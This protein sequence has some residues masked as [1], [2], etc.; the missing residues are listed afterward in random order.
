MVKLSNRLLL[1]SL[2]RPLAKYYHRKRT[3]RIKTYIIFIGAH[4]EVQ[5]YI[6]NI[7][8]KFAD[9]VAKT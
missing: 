5:R 2:F 1:L 7:I 4:A 3:N 8:L 9:Y 6:Y